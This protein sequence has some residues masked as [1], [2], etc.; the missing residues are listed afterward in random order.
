[1]KHHPPAIQR[2]VDDAAA[3]ANVIAWAD[4][5]RGMVVIS[6]GLPGRLAGVA[7]GAGVELAAAF[8][9]RGGRGGVWVDPEK[10]TGGFHEPLP[11]AEA[12]YTGAVLHELAHVVTT[13]GDAPDPATAV[14]A[15]EHTA[16]TLEYT[17]AVSARWHCH[18][19]AAAYVV[20]LLRAVKFRPV[21]ADKIRAW[22]AG[23]LPRYGFTLDAVAQAVGDTVPDGSLR[24]RLAPGGLWETF[25]FA[26]LPTVETRMAA[27]D[28]GGHARAD[29]VRGIA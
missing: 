10:Y 5:P 12:A 26:R 20:F 15:V 13:D 17:A 18:R 29:G 25:L 1:M 9:D 23:D 6:H 2:M 8:G 14:A 7:C 16:H 3:L 24:E 22:V 19:W 21:L 4:F 11:S 28:A 27:I